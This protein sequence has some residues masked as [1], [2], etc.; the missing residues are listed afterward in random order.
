MI[1]SRF[2]RVTQRT[3]SFLPAHHRTKKPNTTTTMAKFFVASSSPSPRLLLLLLAIVI[4]ACGH[5]RLHDDDDDLIFI[6][7]IQAFII[8]QPPASSRRHLHH[9]PHR[10]IIINGPLSLPLYHVSREE[11][12]SRLAFSSSRSASSSSTTTALFGIPKMFRWL[13]DQYPDILNRQLE[14]NGLDENLIVDNLYLD[15]NGIIHP[16]THGD[17]NDSAERILLDET[18][19]FKKIFLYVDRCVITDF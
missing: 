4:L 11:K 10:Q 6:P 15:M 1:H 3:F 14:S 16:C 13:T 19:M 8:P 5:F 17:N 18:A 12:E 7:T 2:R 9:Q